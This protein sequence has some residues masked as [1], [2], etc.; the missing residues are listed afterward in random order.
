MSCVGQV[1]LNL[2]RVP[3]PAK[4]PALCTL[5][6]LPAEI[7]DRER[8]DDKATVEKAVGALKSVASSFTAKDEHAHVNLFECRRLRGFWPCYAESGSDVVLAVCSLLC[9]RCTW[10]H[11]ACSF[12]YSSISIVLLF[13]CSIVLLFYCSIVPQFDC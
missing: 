2:T 5:K 10:V 4:D 1:E 7:Y 8:E 13:Y 9:A 3:M 11:Y 12:F 6:M